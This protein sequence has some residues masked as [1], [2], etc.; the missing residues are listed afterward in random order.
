MDIWNLHVRWFER[1]T[2]CWDHLLTQHA[3]VV[4]CIMY[5]QVYLYMC[6]CLCIYAFMY[7]FDVY[8]CVCILV[9]VSVLCTRCMLL[10]SSAQASCPGCERKSPLWSKFCPQHEHTLLLSLRNTQQI[11]QYE[12]E[13][14]FRFVWIGFVQQ[15]SKQ[16]NAELVSEWGGR[17]IHPI[18]QPSCFPFTHRADWLFDS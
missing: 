11:C 2:S 13:I 8:F 17:G 4:T 6:L 18:R 14:L 16:T 1:N 5:M 12:W 9:F 7:I 15:T 10:S 3:L